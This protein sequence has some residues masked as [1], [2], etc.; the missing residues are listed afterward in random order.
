MLYSEVSESL[1]QGAPELLRDLVSET[2]YRIIERAIHRLM[3]V[4]MHTHMCEPTQTGMNT[5]INIHTHIYTI[6][7][8]I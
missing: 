1:Y 4:H 3:C 6:N 2:R 8:H 5:H 7:I